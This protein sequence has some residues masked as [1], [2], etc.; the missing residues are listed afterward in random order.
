MAEK[1][2]WKGIEINAA[3][4]QGKIVADPI[5]NGDYAFLTL[6]TKYTHRD[7]N[8]Q[9]TD[10]A[11][12]IPLMVEPNGPI[13]TVRNH[14]KANRKLMAWCYYKSWDTDQGPQHQFVAIRFSLGDKPYEEQ[15]T[16]QTGGLPPL[17]G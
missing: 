12:D 10:I 5:F 3:E 8:G 4:F 9:W 6:R 13:N 11:Q 2:E 7:D 15:A 14:I 16:V 1:K 17:P